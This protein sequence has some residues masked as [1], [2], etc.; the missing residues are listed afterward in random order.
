MMGRGLFIVLE[1]TNRT[2]KH[3]FAQILKSQLKKKTG[4][5][6]DVGRTKHRTS[7]VCP[8]LSNY[9]QGYVNPPDQIV[10]HLFSVDR[11]RLSYRLQYLLNKGHTVILQRYVATG[12]AYTIANGRLDLE[13]C[14]QFDT[15]L[16]KPDVLIYL[17][18]D[19]LTQES[20]FDDPDI[21]E[22]PE[23]QNKII[24]QFNQLKEPE[25]L[26]VNISKSNPQQ[27]LEQVLP[28]IMEK[29]RQA[30][31]GELEFAYYD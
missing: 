24:N 14:K 20:V 28:T 30:L 8:I 15:G 18:R 26:T 4:Q 23:M 3:N 12:H 31:E 9:L 10:H 19:P 11:W 21:Y 5:E 13:W 16:L 2:H 25:W 22:N 1:G 29:L 6:I 27:A 7:A 17:E